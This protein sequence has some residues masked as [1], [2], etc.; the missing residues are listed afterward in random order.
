[1]PEAPAAAAAPAVDDTFLRIEEL[2]L[3][4]LEDVVEEE[5]LELRAAEAQTAAVVE[6]EFQEEE[7]AY[8]AE[9]AMVPVEV[10]AVSGG[11][12]SAGPMSVS[13]LEADMLVD[14]VAGRDPRRPRRPRRNNPASRCRRSSRAWRTTWR[15]WRESFFTDQ[16]VSLEED[17]LTDIEEIEKSLTQ[18]EAVAEEAPA[19][20]VAEAPASGGRS[21]RARCQ[22]R[23]CSSAS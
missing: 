9:E 4:M 23:R 18:E 13:E 19:P 8:P 10:A 2:E 1:M 22:R 14:Y 17:I 15:H 7:A 20:P 3:D 11:G 16:E 21:A 5:L 12:V 6:A